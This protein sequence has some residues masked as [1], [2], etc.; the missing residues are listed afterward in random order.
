VMVAT[1]VD[2]ILRRLV[3][4]L[5]ARLLVTIALGSKTEARYLSIVNKT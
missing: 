3:A 4:K 2:E 5:V 1:R